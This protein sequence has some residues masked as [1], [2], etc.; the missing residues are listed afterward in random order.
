MPRSPPAA[1]SLSAPSWRKPRHDTSR[2]GTRIRPLTSWPRIIA[3]AGSGRW[4]SRSMRRA[5]PGTRRSPARRSPSPAPGTP[6]CSYRSL[7]W[8]R[9]GV[10]PRCGPRGGWCA[11]T[12]CAGSSS[13]RRS[14]RSIRTT[15]W[16][17]RYTRR[18]SPS[19][20]RRC[21][22]P[23]TGIGAGVPRG[24]GIRLKYA[25][26][27]FLDDVAA[28]FPEPEVKPLILKENAARLLGLR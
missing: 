1:T 7:R 5:R 17:T 11:S 9:T 12:G 3:S 13:T 27:L 26:P 23:P 16:P 21:S 10:S 14:R 6:T 2:P 4:S 18:S 15:R 8:T 24:G 28:E 22:T 19:G 20:C 25:N